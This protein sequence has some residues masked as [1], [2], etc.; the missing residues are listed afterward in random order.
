M[1]EF[2]FKLTFTEPILGGSPADPEIYSSYIGSNA[3]D[4]ASLAEEIEALGTDAVEE[5]GMTVF[6]RSQ[7]GGPILWNYQIEGFFKDACGMLKRVPKTES[8]KMKAYKKIID[9]LIFVQPR[10]IPIRLSGEIGNCQRPLRAQTMQ[11]DRVALASSEE[12]PAGSSIEFSVQC[13]DEGYIDAV[14]EWLDYGELRGIGQWRNSGK[15][16][17]LW[18]ELDKEGKVID[19]NHERIS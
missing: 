1:K 12:A 8:S 18:D 6:G 9:G 7:D 15:G 13:L 5:K 16:R 14:K 4:A 19:G 11:G 17:F 3:P 10:Q 2:K